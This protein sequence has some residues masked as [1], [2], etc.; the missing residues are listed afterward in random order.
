VT[1][2]ETRFIDVAARGAR[3]T[4]VLV[5]SSRFGSFEVDEDRV[6][7]IDAGILGIPDSTGYVL[8]ETGDDDA[9]YFWLQSIDE[10]DVAFLATTPWQFFPDY[11]LVVGDDELDALALRRPEDAEV[12][13]LLTVHRDGEQ[14]RDITANLLGPVVVNTATRRA[15]QLV[16]EHASYTTQA[17]LV[18]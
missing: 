10:P 9:T 11:E 6:L 16:L 4:A 2:A 14:V 7:H 18:G 8:V 12:F 1:T 13:L 17:S 15:R 3:V 5:E